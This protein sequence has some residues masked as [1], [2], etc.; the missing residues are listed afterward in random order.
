MVGVRFKHILCP[1]KWLWAEFH[2]VVEV[3]LWILSF[4]FCKHTLDAGQLVSF[5]VKYQ[6][7][8]SALVL[9]LNQAGIAIYLTRHSTVAET[10]EALK[11]GSL[12]PSDLKQYFC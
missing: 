6:C 5:V 4:G 12:Q 9:K 10:V 11:N 2:V 1:V 8:K 3:L 7:L